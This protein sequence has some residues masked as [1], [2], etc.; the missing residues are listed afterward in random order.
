MLALCSW[1]NPPRRIYLTHFLGALSKLK[2]FTDGSLLVSSRILSALTTVSYFWYFKFN[3]FFD[4]RHDNLSLIV[5]ARQ[6]AQ[7]SG[8]TL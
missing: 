3:D 7:A 4:G 5:S 1:K 2:A 6:A 8:I